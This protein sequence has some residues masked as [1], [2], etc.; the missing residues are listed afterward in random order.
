M[1]IYFKYL[2]LR[3]QWAKLLIVNPE[4]VFITMTAFRLLGD[5][6]KGRITHIFRTE[7]TQRRFYPNSPKL[8]SVHQFWGGIDISTR[9]YEYDDISDARKI[10]NSEFP[11]GRGRTQTAVYH[12]IGHG[13][14]LHLQNRVRIT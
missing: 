5:G 8:K 14:H 6:K 3:A 7:A 13:F 10:I 9:G 4:L 11:Y 12:S 2:Y 1:K